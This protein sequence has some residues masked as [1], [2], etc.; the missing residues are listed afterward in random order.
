MNTTKYAAT[1]TIPAGQVPTCR[2]AASTMLARLKTTARSSTGDTSEPAAHGERQVPRRVHVVVAGGAVGV[3][4]RVG[5][6]VRD[7]V[8]DDLHAA[9]RAP[10]QDA[11]IGHGR[12]GEHEAT[13]SRV[14]QE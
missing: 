8:D 3:A 5:A 7:V 13:V 2:R 12:R 14:R 6:G 4:A 1:P 10:R 9:P 11:D